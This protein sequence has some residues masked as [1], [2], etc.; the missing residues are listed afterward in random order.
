MKERSRR[1]GCTVGQRKRLIVV[2]AVTRSVNLVVVVIV[3]GGTVVGK[4]GSRMDGGK[5]SRRIVKR[6]NSNS[7]MRAIT[8]IAIFII[9]TARAPC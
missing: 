7:I 5:R 4:V 6:M 3:K 9:L 1:S 2:L 8:D